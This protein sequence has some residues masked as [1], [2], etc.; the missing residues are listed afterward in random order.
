MVL[1]P[2][3]QHLCWLHMARTASRPV[4]AVVLLV[5]WDIG[6]LA[7]RSQ[8][9][10]ALLQLRLGVIPVL[11]QNELLQHTHTHTANIKSNH[12]FLKTFSKESDTQEIKISWSYNLSSRRLLWLLF[13]SFHDPLHPHPHPPPSFCTHLFAPALTG[14]P[15]VS[16]R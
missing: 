3:T 8:G 9:Q 2:K 16:S 1:L 5:Q 4:C 7:L 10:T 12:S 11:V 15:S 6:L 14:S 13:H